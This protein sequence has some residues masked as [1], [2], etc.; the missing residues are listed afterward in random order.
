MDRLDTPDPVDPHFLSQ[1][2]AALQIS[3]TLEI[4]NILQ[5]Q[6]PEGVIQDCTIVDC[7]TSKLGRVWYAVTFGGDNEEVIFKAEM[8]DRILSHLVCRARL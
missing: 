7:G 8:E 3:Q 4:G 6:T 5:Y 2:Q 1:F